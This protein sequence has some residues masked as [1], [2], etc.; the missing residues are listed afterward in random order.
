[1][2]KAVVIAQQPM[3]QVQ[4]FHLGDSKNTGHAD[5]KEGS[6]LYIPINFRGHRLRGGSSVP[7]QRDIGTG[8]KLFRHFASERIPVAGFRV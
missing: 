8:I 3:I 7:R 4:C 6:L 2:N 1:M 5:I